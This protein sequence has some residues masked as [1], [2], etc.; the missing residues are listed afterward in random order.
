M[1]KTKKNIKQKPLS[2]SENPRIKHRN[3][4]KGE[5]ISDK[6]NQTATVKVDSLKVHPVYKKRYHFY[7]KYL[8]ENKNNEYKLGDYVLIEE[9][10]PLSRKKR[11]QIVKK[12]LK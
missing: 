4:Q 10:K 12:I 11:W 8:A 7:K 3:S 1:P 5:V 9:C 6:M 2:S